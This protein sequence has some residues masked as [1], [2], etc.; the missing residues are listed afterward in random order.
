MTTIGNESRPAYVYDADTDTWVPIG[1]GPHTHDEYIDKTII[2]AKGD[3][4]V[5]TAADAVARLGVG[6]EGSVLIADPTSPTGLAWEIIDSLPSQTSQAGKFLTTDG[7]DASWATV[8]ALPDQDGQAGNL[9][10]TDGENLLWV[11]PDKFA[12][13]LNEQTIS[14]NYSI[15]VGY[16]GVSAGP[17]TI[18][19]D[20]VVTV[21][22]GSSWSIV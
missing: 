15:P 3:I 11:E 16:N 1:V 5:G 4:V 13:Q 17:I 2:D 21:P 7:T 12:I 9:L 6:P 19:D 20:V 18:D 10:S 22:S 8:D 14:E